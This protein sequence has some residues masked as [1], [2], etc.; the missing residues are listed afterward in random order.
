MNLALSETPRQVLS[1]T[2][3]GSYLPVTSIQRF[4]GKNYSMFEGS[5]FIL[6]YQNKV[7]ISDLEIE[8]PIQIYQVINSS[9]LI[10]SK[11]SK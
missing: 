9:T 2:R 6:G 5:V 3:Q 11:K 8:L 10:E 7:T 4:N 1:T